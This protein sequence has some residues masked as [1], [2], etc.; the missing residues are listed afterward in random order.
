MSNWTVGAGPGPP[1]GRN[2]S[3]RL[4]EGG[5]NPAL[6]RWLSP[7]IVFQLWKRRLALRLNVLKQILSSKVRV[8]GGKLHYKQTHL[9]NRSWLE[10]LYYC[11]LKVINTALA[12]PGPAIQWFG[13]CFVRAAPA[14]SSRPRLPPALPSL[15]SWQFLHNADI[16]LWDAWR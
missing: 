12:R 9:G 8:G 16:R 3:C 14:D 1:T 4:L 13:L 5:P 15:R 7:T 6:P 10:V 11:S 2:L